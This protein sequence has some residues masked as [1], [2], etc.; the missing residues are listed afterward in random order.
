MS[1]IPNPAAG[2]KAQAGA[3]A[4]AEAG[5]GPS[6]A[7][8]PSAEV[9]A[10]PLSVVRRESGR[11]GPVRPRLWTIL[12][13]LRS[14]ALGLA[15]VGAGLA[16][17]AAL[18]ARGSLPWQAGDEGAAGGPPPAATGQETTAVF[19]LGRLL[20]DGF[21]VTVAPPFGAGD[22]RIARLLVAEGERVEA[23]QP[24][25]ELDNR[26]QL[27][28][29]LA[30]AEAAVH[31]REA[32]LARQRVFVEAS[33]AESRAALERSKVAAATARRELERSQELLARGHVTRAT[34]DDALARSEA[35]E[36]EVESARA[37][38][39]RYT[40]DTPD[41]PPDIA[42]ALRNLDAA[43][44][45]LALAQADLARSQVLAPA[46]GVVLDIHVRPGERPGERGILDMGDIDKMMAEVEVY[47]SRI[48]AIE[49]G[50]TV[51]ITGEAFEGAI[52]GTVERIGW[53]VGR[54]TATGADPAA[55]TDAR[56]IKVHVAIDPADIARV[57]RFTNLQV[58]ARIITGEGT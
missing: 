36:R 49:T 11:P 31:L 28:A 8:A 54:Q 38:L 22:A 2:A 42:V 32:E 13:R 37:T 40:A 45:A 57:R 3:Q 1:S 33:R 47:Q 52:A 14:L 19:G 26:P 39:G 9:S 20:P 12:S 34:H 25:A 56:V 29:A 7:A 21:V 44:A 6:A 35:A 55:R 24:L 46:G 15:L 41:A 4:G 10:L 27:L 48:G 30:S 23:G 58:T 50:D 16:A 5:A 18:Q 51:E 43:R 17:G 53:D